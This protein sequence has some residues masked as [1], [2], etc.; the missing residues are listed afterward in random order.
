[1]WLGAACRICFPSVLFQPLGHLSVFRINELQT[2]SKRLSHTPV[3]R[4][5]FLQIPFRFSG[6]DPCETR[7]AWQLCKTS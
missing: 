1:M 3:S 2:V 5:R 7:H 6:F 4:V